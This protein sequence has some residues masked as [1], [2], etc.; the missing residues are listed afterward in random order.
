MDSTNARCAALL[1]SLALT[2]L[3]QK[4]VITAERVQD[5]ATHLPA[6]SAVGTTS[7]T[8]TIYDA[9][10]N[11][12][13]RWSMKGVGARRVLTMATSV[14][15]NVWKDAEGECF[16]PCA[17]ESSWDSGS[18]SAP[19]V[20]FNPNATDDSKRFLLSYAGAGT[21]S[22]VGMPATAIGVAYSS[23]GRHF[24]R[25]GMVLGG[26]GMSY[27]EPR[28]A[29]VD[30][31]FQLSFFCVKTD[32][33]GIVEQAGLGT[34]CSADGI[35]WDVRND[36]PVTVEVVGKTTST[37]NLVQRLRQLVDAYS[38]CPL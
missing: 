18:I 4:P 24:D 23:D 19:T 22:G 32:A 2:L 30:G 26:S 14:D 29:L 38:E 13:K 5:S 9:S 36:S 16:A 10:E 7:E 1:L 31:Q 17:T 20:V 15:G 37:A 28:L 11:L 8:S 6:L 34:A 35:K 12:W 25:A 21:A 27:G 33:K 3:S